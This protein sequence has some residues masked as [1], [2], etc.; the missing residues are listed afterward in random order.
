M[1][2]KV[3]RPALR[4]SSTSSASGIAATSKGRIATFTLGY[5]HPIEFYLPDGIDMKVDKQTHLVPDGSGPAGAGAGG[6]EHARASA[7]RSIQ[8]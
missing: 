2:F 3:F 7:A 1:R 8:E 6:G 5:S 4:G